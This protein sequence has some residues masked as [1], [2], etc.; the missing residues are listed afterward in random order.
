[1]S[2]IKSVVLTEF[3]FGVDNIGLETAAAGVGNMAWVKGN[4]FKARRWAVR[5]TSDDGTTGEY[6]TNWVGTPSSFGQASMLAPLLV[7]RNPEHRGT[8]LQRPEMGNTGL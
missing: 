6:V 7:G 3:E 4:R 2:R 5:I 8:D 1:M